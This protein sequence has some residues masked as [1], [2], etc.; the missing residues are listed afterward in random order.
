[1]RGREGSVQVLWGEH[2]TRDRDR[3]RETEKQRES[4]LCEREW[5]GEIQKV[6]ERRQPSQHA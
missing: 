2:K 3:G 1:M 6:R 4:V 5:V